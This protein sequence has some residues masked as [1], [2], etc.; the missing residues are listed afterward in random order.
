MKVKH[1]DKPWLKLQKYKGEFF[2][3][4][5]PTVTEMFNITVSE[6]PDNKCFTAYAP[7]ELFFTYK[8]AQETI[9]AVSNYLVKKGV[10]HGDRVA[11]TGKNSPEWAIAYLA[12]LFAGG[13]VIPLDYQL[14]VDEIDYLMKFSDVSILFVDEERFDLQ[15]ADGSVGLTD[16]ISLS[17]EKDNYILNIQDP[18]FIDREMPKEEE[19]AVILFTSGT[20]GNPKGVMLTHRNM[21]SDCFL[22]QG[23]MNLYP[24]DVFYAL[25]PI[26][27]SYTMLAVFFEALSVGA[28]I[29][30]GKKLIVKQILLELKQ[31]K[32]TMFLGVPML[33]NK[34]LKGLLNGIK[35]KGIV[36]YG[37]IR[38]LMSISGFI[39]KTFGVNP[40]KKMFRGLL[41]KLSL[42]TNRI[43]IS[44]GGPLPSSTFKL[45]NQLGID[46][47][48]GYGL[49]ETSPIITLNPI[50]AYKEASVGK[51]LPQ[52]TM[53]LLNPDEKGIGE[54]LVKGP[55]VMQGYYKN[56]EATDA[57][58]T[59][60]GWLMTGDAG[61]ID[62]ENYVYL[63]GRT[64][65][66]I[67]TEGGKNVFP[68]E[69]EDEFQL[70]EE[71]EQ[72]LVVGYLIDKKTKSEGI[73]AMIFPAEA[74]VKRVK[75]TADETGAAEI[76]QKRMEEIVYEVNRRLTGYKHITRVTVVE[77][78]MPMTSTKKI[79]RFEVIKEYSDK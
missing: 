23:L 68:E 15:D 65:S 63:T 74:Y 42:D 27:H 61:Y 38:F 17:P 75:E 71:I 51:I 1:N 47:V 7:E 14:K 6:Y 62:S 72:I 69:I 48:Q 5:W 43:C 30:F 8:E 32:V 12:I 73:R 21:I 79:K 58:F 53:K 29:V 33:F 56:Q 10:K 78:P 54:I 9:L 37:I 18:E 34:L 25:L 52:T 59:E 2:Q 13:T 40:G 19:L 77:K 22:G 35:E 57:I 70:F 20:T 45:F 67:V 46:F 49:T 36:I 39:K 24:S 16:K 66:L 55:M 31:A 44:G 3:G 60:D 76:I 64:K 26:H 41:A 4:E 50:Y 11:V 28:E